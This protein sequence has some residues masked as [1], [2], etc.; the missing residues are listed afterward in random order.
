VAYGYEIA[1]DLVADVGPSLEYFLGRRPVLVPDLAGAKNMAAAPASFDVFDAFEQLGGFG[2]RV[3]RFPP[4]A[5]TSS[6]AL[7]GMSPP[8]RR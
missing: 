8:P 2:A 3:T 4:Y 5:A 6:S 7:A 1:D